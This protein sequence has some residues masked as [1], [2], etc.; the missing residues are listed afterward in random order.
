M[1]V[2][3]IA[4]VVGLLATGCNE[5]ESE[6]HPARSSSENLGGGSEV[7]DLS[8]CTSQ[9]VT[10]SVFKIYL[11]QAGDKEYMVQCANGSPAGKQNV[12]AGDWVAWT[13]DFELEGNDFIRI[14]FDKD[15]PLFGVENRTIKVWKG[16]WTWMRVQDYAEGGR[17]DQ[18]KFEHPYQILGGW[19]YVEQPNPGI[20]VNPPP[21]GGN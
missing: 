13:H 21:G 1:P 20:I 17:A 19:D 3:C 7:A 9:Q 16:E 11:R 4:A 12:R 14:K 15:K 6:E 2:L 5:N 18:E 10:G 8:G